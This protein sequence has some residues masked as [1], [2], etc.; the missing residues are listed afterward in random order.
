MN[1]CLH[2]NKFSVVLKSYCDADWVTDNNEVSSTSGYVFTLGAGAISWKSSKQPCI[3]HSTM[4]SEFIAIELEGQEVELLKNLLADTP[5]WGRQA[6][7]VSLY[8]DS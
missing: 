2:F 4:E 6:S 5:L 7:P 8:C 1:W 3:E